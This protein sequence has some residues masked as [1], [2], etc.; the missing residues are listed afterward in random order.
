MTTR[1]ANATIKGYYYQ[2][3]TSILKLLD[4]QSSND[5]ITVEGVEDI[6]INTATDTTAVQCKYLSKPRFIYSA[7]REPIILMLNHFVD[8]NTPNDYNYV[9]YAH[10]ETAIRGSEPTIDLAILK[11]I[12]TYSD[13]KVKKHYEIEKNISDDQL[14]AFLLQFKFLFG[15]EFDAQQKLIIDKLRIQFNCSDFEADTLYY[16]NALRVVIDKAI[17]RDITL[18]VIS[19]ADFLNE[20]DCSKKFFNEWFI[21]LR[22]KE[23]YF[24]LLAQNFKST[25]ILEP[26]RIKIIL[27]GR[28]ILDANNSELPLLTLIDNLVSKYYKSGSALRDAK[29]L[30]IVLDCERSERLAIKRKLI[31]S[32]IHFNDGY[33]E[34]KFS[35]ETFNKEPVINTTTNGIKIL[36]S[37]YLIKLISKETFETN[38]SNIN[39][40]H[41]LIVFSQID[42]LQRFTEGQFI[43]IKYCDNLKEVHKLLNP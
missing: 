9:L 35:I 15:E 22:S 16:N 6:D 25:K 26:S 43:D 27:I 41:S 4:L 8:D 12:L 30:T 37:S 13:A 2:F 40:P 34:I 42:L 24:K 31:D 3:A 17:Q 38:I 28:N 1:A 21:K 32:Q 18:R 14:N 19:K 5:T 10:F 23:D 11:K 7:V 20:I 39:S 29:P 36:R 33:E